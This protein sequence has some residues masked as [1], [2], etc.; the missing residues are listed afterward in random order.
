MFTFSMEGNN[1]RPRTVRKCRLP[2][3]RAGTPRSVEQI[4]G[5]SWRQTALWRSGRRLFETSENGLD[6]FT[7]V[8]ARFSRR[9]GNGVSRRTTTCLAAMIVTACSGFPEPYATAVH[10]T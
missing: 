3:L 2:G 5:R 6:Y 9:T 10:Q 4:P 7:S 8:P 1:H